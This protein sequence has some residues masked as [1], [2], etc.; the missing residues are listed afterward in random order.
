MLIKDAT[1]D[2]KEKLKVIFYI[3]I[4]CDLQAIACTHSKKL[5]ENERLG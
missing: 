3:F 1:R 4:L 2:G 5:S